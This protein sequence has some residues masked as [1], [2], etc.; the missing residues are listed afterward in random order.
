[1]K[2]V[3]TEYIVVCDAGFSVLKDRAVAFSTKIEKIAPFYELK[4]E[5][6]D[7]EQFEFG[8]G[9]VLMP[10]L[11][12]L[13]THLEYSA[14]LSTLVYGD[15]I[16]W[17]QSVITHRDT[18]ADSCSEVCIDD[19]LKSML[20]SG[21][22]TI[23]AIS[24]FGK[25]LKSCAKSQ[26][27]VIYFNEVLGSAPNAVD[28]MYMDFLDRYEKS[29]EYESERFIPA[30]A[31]HAPYST[32]RVLVNKVLAF[33]KEEGAFISTH[34]MESRYEREWLDNGGGRFGEFLKRFNPHAAPVNEPIEY[35]ELFEG[36]KTLFVHG[37]YANDKE[38]DLMERIG[39]IAHSPRSNRL[40]G[41]RRLEIEMLKNFALV[42]DGLSSNYSLSLWDEMR[43]AIM[44]HQKAPLPKLF[45]SLLLAST[46]YPA[47]LYKLNKGSVEVGKDSDLAVYHFDD[48]DEKNLAQTL[49]LH[50]NEP[51]TL[52]IAGQEVKVLLL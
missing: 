52:Y 30:I 1:M 33:A 42:T 13:H 7:A 38:L 18:L 3:K 9:S 27:N 41:N 22:T 4:A 46:H 20:K 31:V 11:I 47:K 15:F 35:L 43:A 12:N 37:C 40:L 32:H 45:K 28:A 51:K 19:A 17:L 39:M 6:P 50:A 23:G 5:Y 34:F 48:I 16:D 49:L 21:T 24:S 2:I 26:M 8:K 25:D 44:L 14:N 29:K 36:V 10:G